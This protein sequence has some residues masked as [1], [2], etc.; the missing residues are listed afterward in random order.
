MQHY[1]AFHLGFHCLPKY[2]FRSVH[3]TEGYGI[4]MMFISSRESILVQNLEFSVFE[5][6]IN[7]ILVPC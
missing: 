7:K 2:L 3:Y 6:G 5:S 1:A 4:C